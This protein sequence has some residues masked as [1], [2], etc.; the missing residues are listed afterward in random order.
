MSKRIQQKIESLLIDE[1]AHRQHR[2]AFCVLERQAGGPVFRCR[3]RIG[4]NASFNFHPLLE[5]DQACPALAHQGGSPTISQRP[6]SMPETSNIVMPGIN[7]LGNDHGYTKASCGCKR[8]HIGAF[9]EADYQIGL[10]FTYRAAERT[11][12]C[13]LTKG[14]QQRISSRFTRKP[15]V[16]EL[17]VWVKL[18]DWNDFPLQRE[19]SDFMSLFRPGTG[20]NRHDPFGAAALH[21]GNDQRK[22]HGVQLLACAGTVVDRS[23]LPRARSVRVHTLKNIKDTI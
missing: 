6:K 5:P 8:Q 16:P 18:I 17:D 15:Q 2:A 4:N 10:R 19:E 9:H 21:R 13:H 7:A 14:G 22:T 12:P 11:N 20:Q 23:E 1:T 3:N